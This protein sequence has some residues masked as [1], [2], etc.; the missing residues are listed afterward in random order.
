MLKNVENEHQILRS[1]N[2][3]NVGVLE[4]VGS[5]VHNLNSE[6]K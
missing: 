4:T 3:K 2:V 1:K 5:V 6:I